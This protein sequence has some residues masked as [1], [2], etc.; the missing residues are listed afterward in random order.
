MHAC[1]ITPETIEETTTN[2]IITAENITAA[3]TDDINITA[4]D[5]IVINSSDYTNT[6]QT[7]NINST[8]YT[9]QVSNKISNTSTL[10]GQISVDERISISNTTQNLNLLIQSFLTACETITINTATGL[11]TDE[12][13]A[14][15]T[16]LKAQFAALLK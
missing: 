11:L 10:G 16:N 6:A 13:K 3:A 4:H 2:K 1:S 14:V 9:N 5:D 15:F 7:I 8:N 12:S